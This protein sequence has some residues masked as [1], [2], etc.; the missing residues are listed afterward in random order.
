MER[1]ELSLVVSLVVS[2]FW[3]LL[4]H[5]RGQVRCPGLIGMIGMLSARSAEF[6]HQYIGDEIGGLSTRDL[7]LSTRLGRVSGSCG[8]EREAV[9]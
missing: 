2:L 1:L 5:Q 3:A 6:H 9:H 8:H 7:W 4:E